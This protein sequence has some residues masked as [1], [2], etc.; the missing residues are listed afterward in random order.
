MARQ[1][2]A[3]I[4]YFGC[5][6]V[7]EVLDLYSSREL[8]AY[9]FMHKFFF[10][11]FFVVPPTASTPDMA[12]ATEG[13]TST[14]ISCIATGVPLPTVSWTGP[15]GSDIM[16]GSKY[17]ISNTSSLVMV[18]SNEVFQVTS[19][20]TIMSVVRGDT[21]VYSCV[22]MNSVQSNTILTVKCKLLFYLFQLY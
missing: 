14:T 17:T 1:S 8:F 7:T 9:M 20:L 22:V 12:S 13:D 11:F 5:D 3:A 21:G 19:N 15:G 2:G 10:L 6:L 18:G 16:N 4:R